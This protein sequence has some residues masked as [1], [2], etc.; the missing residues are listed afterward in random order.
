[1]STDDDMLQADLRARRE[2]LDVSRSFIVQAPAGSGKT[3]LLIQ[4]YLCLLATVEEPEEVIAITFTRKAANEMQA[5][6]IDALRRARQGATARAE[7]EQRTL[8]AASRILA[9]D[10]E[11]GWHLSDSPRRMRIMTLDAFCAS[12]TRM[13]PAS[14]GLG[15]SLTTAADQGMRRLY[16]DAATA[17]LDWLPGSEPAAAAI[18]RVLEHLDN[19]V[20]AYIEYV[21]AMLARRDQ[22]LE[23]VGSGDVGHPERVRAALEANIAHQVRAQ[24]RLVRARFEAIGGV[25]ERRLLRYAGEQLQA[26]RDT[27]ERLCALRDSAWPRA[28]PADVALWRAIAAMLLKAD[29]DIRSSVNVNNG[30]PP[31]DDGQ[32]AAFTEWLGRL[33]DEPGLADLLNTVQVL[34]DA[35]YRDEQWQVLL[36]LFAV[37]PLAVAELRRLFAENGTTDHVE[38]ARQ[39]AQRSAVRESPANSPCCL[40]TGCSIC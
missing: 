11:R 40:I 28:E 24:L 13:L 34:P 25:A 36:A 23:I 8:R 12:I 38:V 32:K 6:V 2:A 20:G 33:Q 4:R 1:M 15:G 16:L 17:T 39:P 3:E 22:W 7:H 30:F 14:S 26:R 37:L 9:R 18:R 31:G 35:A 27:T 21:A 10:E 5:R 29:G 19:S